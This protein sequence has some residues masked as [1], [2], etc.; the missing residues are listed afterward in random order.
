MVQKI[1]LKRRIKMC[2]S[3]EKTGLM[4]VDQLKDFNMNAHGN[5]V[6]LVIKMMWIK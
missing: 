6:H 5:D 2:F 3:Y 4:T 1:G